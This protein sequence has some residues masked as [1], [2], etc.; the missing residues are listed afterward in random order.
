M[1]SI[2]YQALGQ[3]HPKLERGL[4]WCHTCGRKMS[5]DT[6]ACMRRGWPLCCG[7]T[8]SI[9]SPEERAA[10]AKKPKRHELKVWPEFFEAIADGRKTFEIREN[11]RGFAVG[12]ELFLREWQPDATQDS[13]VLASAGGFTGR[14][15]VRTITYITDFTQRRGFVVMG[16]GT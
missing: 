15:L 3:V 2:D 6:P 13:L 14:L 1:K 4:V 12:D 7:E 10:L 11:D 9:D 16:L 8:M 5:V